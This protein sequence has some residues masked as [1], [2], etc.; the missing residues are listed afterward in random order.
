MMNR[1]FDVL[2]K[3]FGFEEN[4]AGLGSVSRTWSKEVEVAWIGK[5]TVTYKV[6]VRPS[7]SSSDA[8]SVSFMQDGNL[9][10]KKIYS[11]GYARTLNAIKTTIKCAGFEL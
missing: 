10:K 11:F 3:N 8:V 9:V 2:V 1:L 7:L 4:P 6:S 5:Q